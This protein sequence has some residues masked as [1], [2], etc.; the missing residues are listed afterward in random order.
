MQLT[1]NCLSLLLLIKHRSMEV[2]KVL[3]TLKASFF[4]SILLIWPICFSFRPST[5]YAAESDAV[6]IS[7]ATQD[8]DLTIGPEQSHQI[9]LKDG[10][11]AVIGI[12][13]NQWTQ[14][15]MGQLLQQRIWNLDDLLQQPFNVSWIQNQDSELTHCQ[16][17]GTK[18]YDYRL[19]GNKRVLYIE[20]ETG[21]LSTQLWIDGD[22][23]R[24][25][26]VASDHGRQHAPH[27]CKLDLQRLRRFDD[28]NSCT[29][30]HYNRSLL[31]SHRSGYLAYL[32]MV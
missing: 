7:G 11:V 25:R 24:Y 18:I 2:V 4:L 5:A 9:K 14:P 22:G 12:K 1:L 10:T 21:D 3:R 29:L 19:Y 30:R 27:L 15:D 17:L 26:R 16:C 8:F 6:A 32:Q 20:L 31:D 23:V 28:P 13:K